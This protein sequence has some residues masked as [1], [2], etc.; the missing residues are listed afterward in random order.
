MNLHLHAHAA[1]RLALQRP[2]AALL[3]QSLRTYSSVLTQKEA[4]PQLNGY[5]Q[6]PNESRQ[7]LPPHGWWDIQMRRN[8]G[9]TELGESK[10]T[11]LE[12]DD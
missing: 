6:L 8:F 4:D 2:S 9:D 1:A 12:E 7:S 10:K 3:S 5:P 11:S